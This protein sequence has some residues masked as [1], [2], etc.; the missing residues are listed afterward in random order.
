MEISRYSSKFVLMQ[1]VARKI[2]NKCSGCMLAVSIFGSVLFNTKRNGSAWKKVY[3][4][5][6][7]YASVEDY[8]P[9]DYNGTIFAAIELS[10][11]HDENKMFSKDLMWSVLQALSLFNMGLDVP[12]SVVKLAWKSMQPEGEAEYFEAMVNTLIHKNLVDEYIFA[13]YLRL[14][15][16]VGEY[17]ELKKPIDLVTILCDQEGELKQGKELLAV[18]LS[19]YGKQR[20]YVKMLLWRTGAV[21]TEISYN[22]NGGL[23]ELLDSGAE[24]AI[25]AIYQ[26]YKA[27]QQDAKALL[28][29]MH[30]HEYLKASIAAD[31]LVSLTINVGAENLLV[32]G[33]I[34]EFVWLC[35][36]HLQNILSHV[37]KRDW[38]RIM[39]QLANCKAFAKKMICHEPLIILIVENIRKHNFYFFH[40]VKVLMTLVRYVQ[41]VRN[42]RSKE[43]LLERNK[44]LMREPMKSGVLDTT[45]ASHVVLYHGENSSRGIKVPFFEPKFLFEH[46]KWL[47]QRH[48][49]L[50]ATSRN[51]I[52]RLMIFNDII[53][54]LDCLVDITNGATHFVEYGCLELLFC[55]ED[56]G[57]DVMTFQHAINFLSHR[58]IFES[59]SSNGCIRSLVSILKHGTR[60]HIMSVPWILKYLAI[61]HEEVALQ[62]ITK[63]GVE[64]MAQGVKLWDSYPN[65]MLKH[66]LEN[67]GIVRGMILEGSICELLMKV[68]HQNSEGCRSVLSTLI[69]YHGD[70]VAKDLDAKGGL[71]LFLACYSIQPSNPTW[72]QQLLQ[73]MAQNKAFASKM[74]ALGSIEMV[75]DTLNHPMDFEHLTSVAHLVK[76]LVEGFEDRLEILLSKICIGDLLAIHKQLSSKGIFE[77]TFLPRAFAITRRIAMDLLAS[78]HHKCGDF[79]ILLNL[80]ESH[81][82]I[83]T[84]I[85]NRIATNDKIMKEL[86][87]ECSYEICVELLSPKFAI[88]REKKVKSR[89]I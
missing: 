50:K 34:E 2:V 7:Y 22:C 40:Y 45:C 59:I 60:K 52:D 3:A 36:H 84:L 19:I 58:V 20:A 79:Y 67:E 37:I 48:L 8:T 43:N 28:H 46:V 69:R 10:L 82:E 16:L 1:D 70:I 24:N 38:C 62:L 78:N 66:W 73:D 81:E 5:F 61:G 35:T 76:C 29:L 6:K 41:E 44:N 77:F 31:V 15:D 87:S 57:W 42:T 65:G 39:L 71:R 32:D 83:A 30:G 88:S 13:K 23:H 17:L 64:K 27:T 33:D 63:V 18:F 49:Q 54:F 80:A 26:L 55:T 11:D 12:S 85:A 74:V 4:Q 86:F 68:I 56:P 21:F 47:L 25:L 72:I 53:K 9:H 14:H 89:Q 51:Q 75:A